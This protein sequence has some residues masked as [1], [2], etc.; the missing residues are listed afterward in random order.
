MSAFVP[1]LRATE[2]TAIGAT[3]HSTF[4]PPLN[5]AELAA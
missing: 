4:F 2:F 3:V 5:T 1:A